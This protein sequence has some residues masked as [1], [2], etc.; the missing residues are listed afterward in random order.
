MRLGRLVDVGPRRPAFDEDDARSGSTSTARIGDRSTTTPPSQVAW[1]ATLCP[2]PR[3]ASGKPSSRAK[4]MASATS[5]WFAQRATTAG[6][7]SI[8]PFHTLRAR[9]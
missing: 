1:P 6:R 5:R 2:P 8:M 9:S 7:R 3:T 4:A